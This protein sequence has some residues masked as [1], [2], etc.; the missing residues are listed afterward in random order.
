MKMNLIKSAFD[1]INSANFTAWK[2]N[3]DLI[4]LYVL[5]HVLPLLD[6]GMSKDSSLSKRNQSSQDIEATVKK[7]NLGHVEDTFEDRQQ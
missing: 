2:M 4:T 1:G 5:G 7:D 3:L 6:Q